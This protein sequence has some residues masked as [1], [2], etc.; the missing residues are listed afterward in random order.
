[1]TDPP[2]KADPV[3]LHPVNRAHHDDQPWSV[4]LA[5]SVTAGMGSMRFIGWLSA[6]ILAWIAFNVL[7]IFGLRWDP[8][9]FILLN[10]AFSAQATYSAPLILLAANRAAEHDRKVAE[11]D[12][13]HNSETLLLLR[14]LHLDAHGGTCGCLEG[15]DTLDGARA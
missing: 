13:R 8:Y 9:P 14:A 2:R 3:H 6:F 15:L 12:Y 7:A 10:L 11:W 1:M 4:R 5:E